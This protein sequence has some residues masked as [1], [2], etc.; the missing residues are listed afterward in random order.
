MMIG[1]G[2]PSNQSNAPRPKPM[3][4][5]HCCVLEENQHRLREFLQKRKPRETKQAETGIMVSFGSG[6]VD[7]LELFAD[8]HQKRILWRPPLRLP[9][10][11]SKLRPIE[12]PSSPGL[13]PRPF[14][15]SH[16]EPRR[17]QR[18]VASSALRQ[19]RSRPT[20][21]GGA[22]NTLANIGAR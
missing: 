17:R 19:Q 7:W 9:S 11:L 22:E 2:T 4:A 5:S 21:F 12:L 10:S 8:T 13:S 6:G 16:V 3:M 20:R 15:A 1:R 14:F 18:P